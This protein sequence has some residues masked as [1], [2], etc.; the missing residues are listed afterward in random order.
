VKPELALLRRIPGRPSETY[1]RPADSAA[2]FGSTIPGELSE[3]SGG[4]Y[5]PSI[6]MRF[7]LS[8]SVELSSKALGGHSHPEASLCLQNG[9]YQALGSEVLPEVHSPLRARPGGRN[10]GF[11]RMRFAVGF[12]EGSAAMLRL[13][14]SI[15]FTTFSC[16][17]F[18]AGE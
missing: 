16:D 4:K 17:G 7:L 9:P 5:E 12:A 11:A 15:R 14:A 18:R 1:R 6:R 2:S 13:S 8:L 10:E 3:D